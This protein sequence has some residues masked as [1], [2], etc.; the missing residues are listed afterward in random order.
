VFRKIFGRETPQPPQ[1]AP[2]TDFTDQR[3]RELEAS[4]RESQLE[5]KRLT[6]RNS[7]L[8]QQNQDLMAAGPGLS[9]PQKVELQRKEKEYQDMHRQISR[10]ALYL[11]NHFQK[12]IDRG[13][14]AGMDLAEVVTMYLGRVLKQR[15]DVQ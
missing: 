9:E 13:D 6:T 15:E 11:R 14:H 2:A 5:C 1:P 8:F 12:E 4:L 3:I 10:I 7:D